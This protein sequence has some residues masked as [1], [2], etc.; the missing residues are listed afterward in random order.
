MSFLVLMMSAFCKRTAKTA[1]LSLPV[2]FASKISFCGSFAAS[3]YSRHIASSVMDVFDDTVDAWEQI[4]WR[5][6]RYAKLYYFTVSIIKTQEQ[7]DLH[8]EKHSKTIHAKGRMDNMLFL[9]YV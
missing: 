9:V 7:S 8:S 3:A 5:G 2:H 1:A 6:L 4:N